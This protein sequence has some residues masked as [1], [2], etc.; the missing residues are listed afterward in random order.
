[1]SRQRARVPPRRRFFI[2]CEGASEHGYG[3][4][5][6][7]LADESG[8]HLHLDLQDLSGGDP[9]AIVEAACR[10]VKERA[11]RH[12]PFDGRAVL[13]DADRLGQSPHRDVRISPL[14][15]GEGL[16]VIWQRPCHEVLLLHHLRD[17]QMLMPHD[18]AS[19]TAA[20][21]RRWPEYR[22]PM[23]ANQ[24][25]ARISLADVRAAAGVEAELRALLSLL[26]FPFV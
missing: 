26:G 20:L 11:K 7:R 3:A 24:L 10:K 23:S 13:V 18:R 5:L 9:F 15:N 22:K 1:M 25:S 16:S 21:V 6:Q 14:A 8:L 17:C 2:G 4:L 19:A 12:G